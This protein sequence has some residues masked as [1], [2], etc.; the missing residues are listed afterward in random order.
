MTNQ[1]YEQLLESKDFKII[2]KSEL[3][4]DW[5]YKDDGKYYHPDLYP[6]DDIIFELDLKYIKD[7]IVEYE[8]GLFCLSV[9]GEYVWFPYCV[10][11]ESLEIPPIK[12][13]IPDFE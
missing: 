4:F 12:L 10:I 5:E 7:N 9:D 11:E 1:E 13:N 8:D 2:N 3:C 6:I